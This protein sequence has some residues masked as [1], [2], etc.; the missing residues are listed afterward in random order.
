MECNNKELELAINS[1]K[2]KVKTRIEELDK[3]TKDVRYLNNIIPDIVGVKSYESF[4]TDEGILFWNGERVCCRYNNIDYHLLSAP[5][6]VRL[7]LNKH[8]ANFYKF[9][10]GE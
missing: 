6:E 8:L 7:K 5:A 2:D 1:N 10:V 3:I 4:K 9:L